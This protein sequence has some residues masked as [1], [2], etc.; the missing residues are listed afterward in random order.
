[1]PR[2]DR[3]FL[4]LA[5]RASLIALLTSA[6]GC[7]D[8]LRGPQ[9]IGPPLFAFQVRV[10]PGFAEGS[11]FGGTISNTP[12]SGST[13]GLGGEARGQAGTE[14]RVVIHSHPSVEAVPTAPT[15]RDW[16]AQVPLAMAPIMAYDSSQTVGAL[17][18]FLVYAAFATDTA[19][20]MGPSGPAFRVR[21]GYQLVRRSCSSEGVRFE[22]LP[23][24][25]VVVLEPV[26][27][28]HDYEPVALA[29]CGLTP[30]AEDRGRSVT[31]AMDHPG[32]PRFVPL[33]K[34]LAF[35]PHD[36]RV[37][38]TL[39]Y[40]DQE[41]ALELDVL[42]AQTGEVNVV[43]R[44]AFVRWLSLSGDGRYLQAQRLDPR[45]PVV[46]DVR[47]DLTGQ[48]GPSTLMPYRSLPLPSPDGRWEAT[49]LN[50]SRGEALILHE[51]TT[52]QEVRVPA[53]LP[54]VWAPDSSGLLAGRRRTPAADDQSMDLT[55]VR[56]AGQ[57][58][59][60]GALVTPYFNW[61]AW[62]WGL[63][64][65]QLLLVTREDL[66]VV[67]IESGT[68]RILTA[69]EAPLVPQELRMVVS[70]NDG[71]ALAFLW[72]NR[73]DGLGGRQ[74]T[75]RLHR[76]DLADGSS[77]VVAVLRESVTAAVSPDGRRLALAAP[78]AIYLKDL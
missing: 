47:L 55:F 62:V 18:D 70:R 28:T 20:P 67:T 15:T 10:P 14:R 43:E 61:A 72:S 2:L 19:Y 4:A 22:P 42:D 38:F 57:E 21:E 9:D 5:L 26:T 76:F 75:A 64:G 32:D 31:I 66:R 33:A 63:H 29:R 36:G 51:L 48:P 1:M 74:C 39:G 17:N 54:L 59:P 69:P 11:S 16:G 13:F 45:R 24:D 3:T 7:G 65:P 53:A 25:T 77:R 12:P 40:P 56:T 60:R 6:A 41:H 30:P 23:D 34:G 52:G 8:P 50:D 68:T 37:F 35:A 71:P 27:P 49:L 44:G 58:A 46:Q 73:C 78:A